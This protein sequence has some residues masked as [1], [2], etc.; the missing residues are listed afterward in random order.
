MKGRPEKL[1]FSFKLKFQDSLK[2]ATNDLRLSL[3]F[4]QQEFKNSI[5]F[6]DACVLAS[7]MG[8]ES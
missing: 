3:L 8:V 7:K 4:S 1:A 5:C 6:C 2:L